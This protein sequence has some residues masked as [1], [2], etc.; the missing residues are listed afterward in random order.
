MSCQQDV[1]MQRA[2]S[3]YKERFKTQ[4]SLKHICKVYVPTFVNS[5][6]A[7]GVRVN[8]E[9]YSDISLPIFMGFLKT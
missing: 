4:M 1:N 2:Q 6:G 3:P 5:A 8:I 9:V 7:R